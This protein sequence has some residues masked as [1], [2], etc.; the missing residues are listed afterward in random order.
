M[1]DNVLKKAAFGGFKK[2][3]VLDYVEKLQV[4]LVEAKRTAEQNKTDKAALEDA[5]L[6]AE[7]AEKELGDVKT[8][9]CELEEKVETYR[10]KLAGYDEELSALE[11]RFTALE[12]NFANLSENEAKVNDIVQDAVRYSEQVVGTAKEEARA[13]SERAKENISSTAGEINAISEDINKI[14]TDFGTVITRLSDRISTLFTD[15]G[16]LATR[17]EDDT[18]AKPDAVVAQSNS[19]EEI[20]DRNRNFN[21]Y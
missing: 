19:S 5:L 13:V 20:S 4:Q 11:E 2:S 7:K 16:S 10:K 9:N 12:E 6:R 8:H 15:I 1:A 3:D 21:E 14:A 17:F 18:Q